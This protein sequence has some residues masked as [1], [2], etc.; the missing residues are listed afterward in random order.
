[1]IQSLLMLEEQSPDGDED[2]YIYRERER[3]LTC[4]SATYI[5]QICCKSVEGFSCL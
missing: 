2:I 4:K 5:Y 1:M 3:E